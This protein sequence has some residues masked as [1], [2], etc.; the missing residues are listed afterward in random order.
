M[1]ELNNDDANRIADAL[2]DKGYILLDTILPA[3]LVDELYVRASTLGENAYKRAKIGRGSVQ[4]RND[5]IRSDA[6]CWLEGDDSS[7]AD[8]LAWMESLRI[9]MNRYLY[10][11]LFDYECHFAHYKAGDFYKKHL[12]AL[13]GSSN[14]ILTTVFY[15]NP[16][17]SE[18]D[19]GQ[20]LLYDVSDTKVIERITPKMGTLALFLSEKFPHEVLKSNRDRYSIAGWFRLN[21]SKSNHINTLN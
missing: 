1:Y 15:L 8:Y 5:T 11:G 19:G 20:M 12:D 21:D 2:V 17:W 18:S 6:T 13:R 10:L 7:E 16:E 9:Y 4:Q 3:P 14:R